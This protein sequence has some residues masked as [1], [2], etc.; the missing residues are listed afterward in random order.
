LNF[1]QKFTW[2]GK[3]ELACLKVAGQL[4]ISWE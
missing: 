3:G 4:V 2:R 1:Y